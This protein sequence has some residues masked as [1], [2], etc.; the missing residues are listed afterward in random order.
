MGTSVLYDICQSEDPGFSILSMCVD[1]Q[2]ATLAPSD[3]PSCI[4]M[5]V[6]SHGG[7]PLAG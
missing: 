3:V 7:T 4:N 2:D 5:G 6:Q 1:Q